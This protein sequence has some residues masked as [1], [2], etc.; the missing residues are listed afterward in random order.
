MYDALEKDAVL[1]EEGL[2]VD[3]THRLTRLLRGLQLCAGYLPDEESGEL[4]WI[5]HTKTDAILADLA[6][7]LASDERIVIS[8]LF[9]PSGQK[10]YEAVARRYGKEAVE[11]V[12]GDTKNAAEIL[13]R[14]DVNNTSTTD[15]LR[16]VVLQEQV[17]GVGISLARARHLFFHSWSMDSAAHEQMRLRIWT[18]S[19]VSNISYYTMKHSADGYALKIVQDKLNAS[20]MKK[21]GGLAYAFRGGI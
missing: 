19:K 5:H 3:G 7:P 20:V 15:L 1:F 10:L 17:G 21:P 9:T 14:F 11:W 8:Y 13:R 16:V 4:R 12:Y 6:E 2:S 18:P